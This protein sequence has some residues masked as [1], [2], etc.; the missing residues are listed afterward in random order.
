[1]T[2]TDLTTPPDLRETRSAARR[3]WVPE[4]TAMM[5]LATPIALVSLVNMAM[6]VTDTIM[7][8]GLGAEGSSA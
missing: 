6:N 4:A 7:S 3:A 8:A 5:R 1:M 2:V